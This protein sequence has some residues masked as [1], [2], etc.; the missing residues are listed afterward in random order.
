MA[1]WFISPSQHVVAIGQDPIWPVEALLGI[2]TIK[3]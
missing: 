2:S 3:E 1:Q